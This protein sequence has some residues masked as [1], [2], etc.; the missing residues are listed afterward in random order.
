MAVKQTKKKKRKGNYDGKPG[1]LARARSL[2]DVRRKEIASDAA[3]K[4]WA[5]NDDSGKKTSS[6]T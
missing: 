2:S 3:K 1:A 6:T 4:R 5:K